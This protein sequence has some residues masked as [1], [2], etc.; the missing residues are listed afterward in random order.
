VLKNYGDVNLPAKSMICK[1]IEG[2]CKDACEIPEIKAGESVEVTIKGCS[3]GIHTWHM[4][5]PDNTIIAHVDC[6]EIYRQVEIRAQDISCIYEIP[7][8]SPCYETI[9]ATLTVK[10]YKDGKEYTETKIGKFSIEVDK[11]SE[12]VLEAGRLNGYIFSYWDDFGC[13]GHSTSN[14]RKVRLS[15]CIPLHHDKNIEIAYFTPV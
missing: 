14:P 12:I 1:E 7:E 3:E 5:G 15:S 2:K 11:G 9:P 6:P 4:I 13:K 8:E 10:Y